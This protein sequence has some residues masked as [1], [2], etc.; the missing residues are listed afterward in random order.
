M[1]D[2]YKRPGWYPDPDGKPGERWW[3]GSTWSDSRRG[4]ATTAPV[5]PPLV[6]S[7]DNPAPQRADPYATPVSIPGA[8]A[9]PA[10]SIDTRQNRPALIG[11]I[12]GLISLFA[13]NLAG[14]V[15]IVFSV[16]GI[17]RARRLKAEGM[18]T[19][20]TVVLATIGLAA[21]VVATVLLIVA[22]VATIATF[23][24]NYDS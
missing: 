6:Y 10:F 18:A 15:A 11:F 5:T 24:F 2:D 14:P 12:L 23:T 8:A 16:I 9:R 22:I 21:G 17:V 20:S 1:A 7:A 19:S 4:G 13:F 3:N